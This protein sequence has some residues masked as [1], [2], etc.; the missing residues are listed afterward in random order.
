MNL[1][2]KNSEYCSLSRIALEF[3]LEINEKNIPFTEKNIKIYSKLLN[4]YID[5]NK[6]CKN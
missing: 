4:Q 3:V 1:L 5:N 6:F 2:I